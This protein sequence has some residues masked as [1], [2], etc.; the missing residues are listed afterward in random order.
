MKT[1]PELIFLNKEDIKYE[2]IL[3]SGSD[4]VLIS[5]I[6]EFIINKFK[7]RNY[8]IDT[9]GVINSPFSGDLFSE[10]K[11]ISVLKNPSFKKGVFKSPDDYGQSIIISAPNGK[12]LNPLK[13]EFSKSKNA[14]LVDCYPL[15]RASKE[16]IL[17]NLIKES[18][19]QV[20]PDVFFYII[21]NFDDRYV[22]YSSQIKTLSLFKSNFEHIE[23]VEDVVFVENKI[24]INK[25]LFHI[26]HK[27][28]KLVKVFNNTILSQADFY[29]FLNSLKLYLGIISGSKNKEDAL[30]KFPKYLF[31][32]RDIFVK[33]YNGLSSK[34]ALKIYK[35]ILKV[36]SLVRK[37]SNLYFE[38]GLR[39]L[40]NTKKIITS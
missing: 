36:E 5:H 19:M 10:K 37:N 8:Q 31:N 11:I 13:A 35:N 18:N 9:S 39:F 15:N 32:E 1:K 21:E 33:I 7:E 2:K 22:F 12:N 23:E 6:T 25:I 40:I 28:T 29:I 20:S 24:D 30:S 38:I 26:F 14:L 34:K 3:V 16:V 27:N 4:E 17:K